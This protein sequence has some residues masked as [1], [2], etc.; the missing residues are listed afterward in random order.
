IISDGISNTLVIR[1]FLEH[2]HRK[3]ASPLRIQYKDYATWITSEQQQDYVGK[4]K[5]FWL[6]QYAHIPEALNVPTDFVRPQERNYSSDIV[7]MEL[8]I[9]ETERLKSLAEE[10]GCTMFMLLLSSYHLLLSKLSGQEDI[11]IGVPVAGR[12]HVDLEQLIGVF[13]N[14]VCL[15]NQAVGDESFQT[16]LRR[17]K[18]Q[19][20]NSFDNQ[21]YPYEELIN[22]LQLERDPS[23]NPL[24]DVMFTYQNQENQEYKTPYSFDNKHKAALFDI[25]LTA[26]EQI[27][28]AMRLEFAYQTSLY[29]RDTMERFVGYFKEIL[30]I[31]SQDMNIRL[32]AI[33]VL[34]ASERQQLL[35]DFN[36]T[37][38]TYPAGET[39]VSVLDAQA[40]L[41][42]DKVALRFGE[43]Q[44]SYSELKSASDR[45]A[46]YLK[47]IHD[48][49]SGDLIGL[50]LERELQLLP[51]IYG[52]LKAGAA[53]VPLSPDYPV[54]RKQTIMERA[55]LSAMVTRKAFAEDELS[56]ETI[57][58][59][60]LD[61]AGEVIDKQETEGFTA[62]VSAE[63]LAYVIHT[64]GS[65]GVPKGVMI[66]H[67]SAVNRLRW[68][69]D[70]YP[71]SDSDVLLQKTPLVF[72]V[73][74]WE[75]F[76]WSFA[77][78]SLALLEPEGEKDPKQLTAAIE[79]HGVS[80][81]H[82]VPSMLNVF[83]SVLNEESY[84]QLLSLRQV[85]TSGEALRPDHVN[86]F[87]EGVHQHTGSRLTNLYGPTEATVDVTYYDCEL[88]EETTR[89]P[90]GKPVANTQL[91]IL[92]ANDK[93][94]PLGSYGELC[95]GGVQLAKGYLHQPELT[96]E[97]FKEHPEF[98][99][100]YH[101]GDLARW[102]PDGNIEY[103][104]RIDTQVKVRGFRIELGEIEHQLLKYEGLATVVV[105][106]KH[107]GGDPYLVGYYV[108][109]N[110]EAAEIDVQDLRSH[111]S[112][113]LPEYMVPNSF[114]K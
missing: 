51:Y 16:F 10:S 58:L 69:Q 73:S 42:P 85:F 97:K 47:E 90:I 111:L 81:L 34:P 23:R 103:S 57:D 32:S 44:L 35:V 7:S 31:V 15:R 56:F 37:A 110:P 104:G 27:T 114:M 30:K 88:I 93:L 49:K 17:I 38:I 28:G 112:K 22:E 89:V 20:L 50:M 29:K 108:H 65:T 99:R 52:I 43:E 60:D 61:K 2:Y 18:T 100:I 68:M 25:H 82:F 6:D 72:D 13:I 11:V 45:F 12:H 14:T 75:L 98:G 107:K 5:T 83:L 106:V 8:T 46:A 21:G 26:W 24:F 80:V 40:E 96:A 71:L 36:D 66:T 76:W 33:N 48:I 54:E 64:S 84:Q 86:Q 87:R 109:N 78:S 9:K 95:I 4:Q 62:T 59:I 41:T 105:D 63:D 53:Y 101:T 102:L 91:Y 70:A 74:V 77:G 67:G 39:L 1:E 79:S 55:G 94:S 3:P 92:D 113:T 19:T